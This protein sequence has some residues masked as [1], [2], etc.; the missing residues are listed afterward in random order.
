MNVIT[1]CDVCLSADTQLG[2][3]K[4]KAACNT[5]FY[6][7]LESRCRIS[8]GSPILSYEVESTCCLAFPVPASVC[9]IIPE[10]Y[11]DMVGLPPM[12]RKSDI[13]LIPHS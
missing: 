11:S 7:P 3:T 9:V 5:L 10:V 4:F 6:F 8:R 2:Y 13:L 12:E 1:R